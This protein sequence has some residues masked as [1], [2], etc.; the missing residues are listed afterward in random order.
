MAPPQPLDAILLVYHH[1]DTEDAPTIR[2]HVGAFGRHSQFPVF[3]V[4]T[5]HGFPAVL[6]RMRFKNV[7]LHYSLFGVADYPLPDRFRQYLSSDG[8]NKTAF[9]QDEHQHCPTR[10]AFIDEHQVSTV[11][12]LLEAPYADEVYG[13]CPSVRSIRSTLTGYVSDELVDRARRLGRP[14]AERTIDVGYRAR[15]LPFYLGRGS[16]EKHEVGE[17]FVRRSAGSGLRIDIETDESSRIYGKRWYDFVAQ[18]RAMLGVEAGAS[19]F[20]L[21]D[22][23]RRRTERLLGEQPDADFDAV[24]TQVLDEYEDKIPYRTISPR[25]FEAAAFRV[26]QVLYEGHYSGVLEPDVHYLPLAKDWSNFEEI[27]AR[28]NDPSVRRELTDRAYDDLI[29]SGRYSYREFITEFDLYLRKEGFEPSMSESEQ[30]A[31]RRQLR[32]WRR[33]RGVAR[34]VGQY[35][36]RARLLSA[37]TYRKARKTL[38]RTPRP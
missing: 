9:F 2:E 7:V 3:T 16:Q 4:N 17:E 37:A 8:S 25:H 23:A 6:D 34:S 29:A 1:F 5:E 14:D 10:F 31:V 33:A 28:L 30:R 11:Y 32:R 15:R 22:S 36:A 24:A 13:R 27:L 19:V 35:P 26:V 20:D 21:D 12:T 38:K 18:C